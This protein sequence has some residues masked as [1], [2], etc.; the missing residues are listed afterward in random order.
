MSTPTPAPAP[1]AD[2]AARLAYTQ[3]LDCVHCGLCTQYCPTFRITGD[4]SQNPRGRIY[5]MR[6]E[7]EGR[8]TKTPDFVEAMDSCLVCRACEAV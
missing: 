6:A 3:S 7:L 2:P 1:T 4:E 5:L 8:I